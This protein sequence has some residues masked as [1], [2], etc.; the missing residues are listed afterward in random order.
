M[1]K[2]S[3]VY[4]GLTLQNDAGASQCGTFAACVTRSCFGLLVILD[5]APSDLSR[6]T[7]EWELFCFTGKVEKVSILTA[8]WDMPKET[9]QE[10]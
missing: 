3:A 10:N 5:E 7:P 1:K 4:L 8:F 6:Y 2:S 9:G